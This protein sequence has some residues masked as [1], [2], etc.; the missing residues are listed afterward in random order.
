M[1]SRV[2]CVVLPF[3]GQGHINPMLQFSKLL[4]HEGMRITLVTTH[5][6]GKSLQSVPPSIALETISD[7][8][9]NGNMERFW[10]VVPKTLAELLEKL[11]HVDCI[12]YDSFFSWALHIAKKFGILAVVFFTQNMSVNS[13]YYHLHLGKL[14]PPLTQD[15]ISLPFLPKLQLQD[16]PSFFF[17]Y[18]EN[19]GAL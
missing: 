14:K 2:H 18:Q 6:Y 8:C 16:M 9:D 10:E 12:I 11:D 5:F 4:Q 13:I 3:P 17:T 1:A 19:P 15:E 7:G